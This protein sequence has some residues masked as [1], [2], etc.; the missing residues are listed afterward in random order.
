MN[1]AS[2]SRLV[3]FGSVLRA[4]LRLVFGSVSGRLALAVAAVVGLV[5]VAATQAVVR[6]VAEAEDGSL[7]Q[8]ISEVSAIE[9]AGWALVGRNFFVLPL[10]LLLAAGRAQ[11]GELGRHTLREALLRPVG[12]SDL[13]LAKLSA[14]AA[15]S[16]STLAVTASLSLGLGMVLFAPGTRPV[17]E[18]LL[19][20]LASGASDLGLLCLGLLVGC[21]VRS[22][23]TV[24]VG[25]VLALVADAALRAAL[26]LMGVVGVEGAGELAGLLPGAA[27]ACWEGW[28]SGWEPGRFVG[29]APLVGVSLGAALWRFERMDIP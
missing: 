26:T 2:P 25:T 14:L 8:A 24:V 6:G 9:V 7:V 12:R 13:L 10:V 11:A 19:G 29:L 4:E 5:A 23:G 21:F 27:L 20:Y 3:I 16:A 15:L 22:A 18:V 1:P 28:E 17:S